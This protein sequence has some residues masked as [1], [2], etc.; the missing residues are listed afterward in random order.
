MNWL[1]FMT[2]I[3]NDEVLQKLGIVFVGYEVGS[4]LREQLHKINANIE[5]ASVYDA[6]PYRTTSMH[7]C[8]NDTTLKAGFNMFFQFY[9]QRVRVRF[10]EHFGTS[11]MECQ[12]K[13]MSYG[14]SPEMLP[15]DHEGRMKKPFIERHIDRLRTLRYEGGDAMD[16]QAVEGTTATHYNSTIEVATDNDVL[17]GRGIPCQ[18]HPGNIRLG[19]LI[20]SKQTEFIK[21]SKF[22][23]TLMTYDI[24][25]V[26]H[27]KYN[28]R[29]LEK[30]PKDGT[31]KV[32]STD[33]A[34]NKVSYGF[35]SLVKS[36]RKYGGGSSTSSLSSSSSLSVKVRSNNKCKGGSNYNPKDG[37]QSYCENM[38]CGIDFTGRDATR[39]N[40]T[41]SSI[42]NNN[43][44]RLEKK[45]KD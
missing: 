18:T 1:V 17:L 21:S 16:V 10:R 31:W 32:C 40:R 33:I 19:K 3:E 37:G 45:T 14:I 44:N 8:Y 7:Y 42:N 28:S 43:N 30:D 4:S 29:F 35:R 9:P 11:H 12:Y 22:D 24:M 20:Q 38:F 36:Q 41:S 26:M 39:S 13:I 6:L 15:V 25:K 27:N 5:F 34:R 23:K 2:S